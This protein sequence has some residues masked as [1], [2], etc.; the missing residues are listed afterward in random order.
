MSD[1]RPL[2]GGGA[3]GGQLCF[4]LLYLGILVLFFNPSDMMLS[5]KLKQAYSLQ[6]TVVGLHKDHDK[7][8]FPRWHRRYQMHRVRGTS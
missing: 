2:W 1:F 3:L 5:T 8:A 4:N 7:G 6:L